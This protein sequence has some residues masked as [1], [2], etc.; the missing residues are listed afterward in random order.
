MMTKIF[1]KGAVA[2][3]LLGI[4]LSTARCDQPPPKCAA[5]RSAFFALFTPAAGSPASCADTKGEG[6]AISTYS[7]IGPDN[8]KPNLD[9]AS[10]AIL[11]SDLSGLV[12][13][14]AGEDAKDP[15]STHTA[16]SLGFFDSATPGGD[17][18][19]R[20]PQL[21]T[22][23]QN[24]PGYPADPDNDITDPVAATSISYA[25]S[26]VRFYVTAQ[27]LGLQMA[28]DV[29]KTVDGVACNYHVEA[30][31]P[32][33][34]CAAPDPSDPTGEKTVA[35]DRLCGHTPVQGLPDPTFGT[36]DFIGSQ[37]S[38]DFPVKCDPDFKICVLTKP[39][40]ALN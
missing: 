9:I 26:N 11:P 25:W 20:V 21:T 18:F 8:Q 35:D 34:S 15:D 7:A 32:N 24:I 37:I 16:Y 13:T 27:Y 22:T 17:D 5:G 3:S 6:F 33:T 4:V 23:I 39:I 1:A 40:P 28:G 2:L 31:S 14:A 38:P 12:D 30:L 10:V 36:P 19:C 29:V